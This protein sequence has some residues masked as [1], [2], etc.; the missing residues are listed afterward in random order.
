M[1][2]KRIWDVRF[3][4]LNRLIIQKDKLIACLKAFV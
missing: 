4:N 2:K 1:L 3:E